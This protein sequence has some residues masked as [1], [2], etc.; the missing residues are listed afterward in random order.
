MNLITKIK[1][2]KEYS[3]AIILL[4]IPLIAAVVMMYP[5]HEEFVATGDITSVEELGVEG[6]VYFTYVHEGIIENLYEKFSVSLTSRNE[7][8]FS[9][10]DQHQYENYTAY[11]ETSDKYKHNTIVNAVQNAEVKTD[12][13]TIK[14]SE[15]SQKIMEKSSDYIGD[16]FGLMIAIG[17]IEEWNDEDFSQNNQYIISGTGTI[18][19]DGT[20]GSV[21]AIRHKLLSAE[22]N[23]VDIFFVPKDREYYA[24]KNF[25]NQVEAKKVVKEEQL[26]VKVIPVANLDEALEY[27]RKLP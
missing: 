15:K 25:S 3:L 14:I 6:S 1:E 7:I 13:Q 10:L 19:Y 23:D 18:E 16:S 26:T 4:I 27:L 21:G 20:V 9:S 17:L 12:S 8:E 24:D 5:K 11:Y 22:M 2:K